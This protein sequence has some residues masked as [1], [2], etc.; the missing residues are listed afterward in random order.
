MLK[1]GCRQS[2]HRLVQGHH[3]KLVV[4]CKLK[5]VSIQTQFFVTSSTN[6][7]F[8]NVQK[9]FACLRADTHGML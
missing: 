5:G 7:S 2:R 3:D 1:K 6:Q 4:K 9:R 8:M